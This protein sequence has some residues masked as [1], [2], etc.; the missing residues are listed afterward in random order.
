MTIIL[1]SRKMFDLKALTDLGS[2]TVPTNDKVRNDR[3]ILKQP[4]HYQK[5][6][7]Y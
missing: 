3:L 1:V 2:C 4:H 5:Y 7:R 6:Y